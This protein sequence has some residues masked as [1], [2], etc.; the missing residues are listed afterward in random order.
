MDVRN[1]RL[2]IS[3]IQ[4]HCRV[5][6]EL[7]VFRSRSLRYVSQGQDQL[8]VCMLLSQILLAHMQKFEEA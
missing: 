1:F 8:K 2:E 7:K 3:V 5:T 6:G 4:L